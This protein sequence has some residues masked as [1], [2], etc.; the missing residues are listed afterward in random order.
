MSIVPGHF[1][2][3]VGGEPAWE[4]ATLYPPQGAWTVAD[5]LG[6]TDSTN[7]LVE[8]VNGHVEVLEMPTTGHQLILSFLHLAL[9]NFA[10][11]R[12]LGLA[13]FAALRLRLNETTFR[14]PDILFVS[15]ERRELA[16]NRFWM[17]ADLVMEIVS[18]DA[19]SRNRDLVEK[20]ADYA[21][22]GIAAYWIVDPR[23]KRITVL[24][25]KGDAYA[26]HAEG[27][28]GEQVAS[29]LLEGFVV[30]VTQTLAAAQE[31]G[32]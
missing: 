19:A 15:N 16:Q 26:V 21:A 3:S 20:R 5:Y 7:H 10:A 29:A 31:F 1:A 22:A 12:K 28:L 14:E 11:E 27:T 32:T 6:F 4:I 24:T 18:D 17:G 30:D 8:F 2:T 23:E 9:S 25:L 13:A